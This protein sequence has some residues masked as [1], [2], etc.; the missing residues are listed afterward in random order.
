M[1]PHVRDEVVLGA[2]ARE[3]ILRHDPP[4]LSTHERLL[5]LLLLLRL[6]VLLLIYHDL[7]IID[8]INYRRP[9]SF[10]IKTE[11]K[12]LLNT[13]DPCRVLFASSYEVNDA[14]HAVLLNVG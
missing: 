8:S 1:V 6:E 9:G 14:S 5:L 4:L 13:A 7:L 12:S 10:I 11:L 3:Q 2:E